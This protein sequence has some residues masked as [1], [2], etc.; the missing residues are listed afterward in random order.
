NAPYFS[1]FKDDLQTLYQDAK[2]F[3]LSEIN[4]HF[5]DYVCGVLEIKTRISDSNDYEL[6]EDR[7]MRLVHIC[8]QL[9]ATEYVSGPR[10]KG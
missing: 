7:N 1:D 10:A 3:S 8:Q 4:K 9:N 6:V 5:L 2:S